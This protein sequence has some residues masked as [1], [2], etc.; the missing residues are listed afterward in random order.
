MSD[1]RNVKDGYMKCEVGV[2]R[3]VKT[4]GLGALIAPLLSIGL[5]TPANADA[6]AKPKVLYKD[7]CWVTLNK[8][9]V[10]LANRNPKLIAYP[11]TITCMPHSTFW[12]NQVIWEDDGGLLSNDY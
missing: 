9:E 12:F 5:A 7:G 11:V 1:L 4:I 2:S 6:A 3:A 10:A 8:P